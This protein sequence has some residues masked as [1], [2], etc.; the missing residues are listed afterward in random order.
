[1]NTESIIEEDEGNHEDIESENEDEQVHVIILFPL[2]HIDSNNS[3][4]TSALSPHQH[5]CHIHLFCQIQL[6]IHW[7]NFPLCSLMRNYSREILQRVMQNRHLD[8]KIISE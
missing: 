4:T 5:M 2:N 8:F 7:V 1:M 3:I 6:F